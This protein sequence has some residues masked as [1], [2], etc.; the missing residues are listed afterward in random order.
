MCNAYRA[1]RNL[2]TR[3]GKTPS[4]SDLLRAGEGRWQRCEQPGPGATCP[5]GLWRRQWPPCPGGGSFQASRCPQRCWPLPGA[6]PY[7][8]RAWGNLIQKTHKKFLSTGSRTQTSSEKNICHSFQ[9]DMFTEHCTREGCG[10]RHP[11]P[12]MQSPVRGREACVCD[13]VPFVGDPM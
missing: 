2:F 6:F 11:W 8:P 3:E 7:N 10:H 13:A 9:I 5:R 12:T 1:V 4:P